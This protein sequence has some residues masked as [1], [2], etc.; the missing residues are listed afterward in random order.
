M[1]RIV[2]PVRVA[3]VF[4][5]T[6]EIVCDALVDTGS[7]FLV[8]PT[9]WKDRLG[10]PTIR[11]VRLELADQRVI[12]GD[13]CGPARVQIEGFELV[14][15]DVVFMEMEPVAGRHEPLVGYLVLEASQAAVDMVGHRLV[16]VD[17]LDLKAAR[18]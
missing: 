5:T 6:K 3:N 18:S 7:A 9:A 12:S 11:Q 15:S 2:T 1:G 14:H 4:D 16:K 17:A 8:L 10:I 13:L